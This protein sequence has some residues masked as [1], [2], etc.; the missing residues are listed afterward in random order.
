MN[1]KQIAAALLGL[2]L[3]GCSSQQSIADSEVLERPNILWLTFEDT[4]A[5]EW[6]LYGNQDVQNPTLESLANDNSLV[7]Q[8]AFSNGPYC[9]PAR[10]TL[11]SGSYATTFGTDHHRA[12]I[13]SPADRIFFPALL[14]QAG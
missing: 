2:S 3:L 1:L 5:D 9:S 7:F 11:I 4:T 13:Q 12:N 10:S 8:Q 6:S 14:K